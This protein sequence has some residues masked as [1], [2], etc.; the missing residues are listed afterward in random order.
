M[1]CF[2]EYHSKGGPLKVTESR[3]MTLVDTFLDAGKEMGEHII[4][5]NGYSQDGNRKMQ[6]TYCNVTGC[7]NYTGQGKILLDMAKCFTLK[8]YCKKPIL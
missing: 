4:D 2:P 3:A 6:S 1:S 8:L 7:K 5:C